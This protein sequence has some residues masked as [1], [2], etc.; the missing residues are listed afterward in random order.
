MTEAAVL[1]AL[2]LETLLGHA[3]D[4]AITAGDTV[5]RLL[6]DT[7]TICDLVRVSPAPAT[8]GAFHA[9]QARLRSIRPDPRG[10]A[11]Q[12]WNG[13]VW[14]HLANAGVDRSPTS[15]ETTPAG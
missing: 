3:T 2:T 5:V 15:S 12:Y 13:R 9:L 14:R 1:D 7:G 6:D 4:D 10:V 11:W 8:P